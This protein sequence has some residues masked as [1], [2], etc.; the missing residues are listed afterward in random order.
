M[1]RRFLTVFA[2]ISV[3][4][5]MLL[6]FSVTAYVGSF[7]DARVTAEE[8]DAPS[9]EI[10]YQN[11]S[12]RDNVCIKFALDLKNVTDAVLLVWT[13]PQ[14]EYVYGTQAA[15][16]DTVGTQKIGNGTYYVYDYTE[17]SAKQM[18]DEIYV[19]GYA[20]I[21]GE[22]VYSQVTRYSIL[23]YALRI[24][25]KIGH[26]EDLTDDQTLISM[27]EQ[28]LEY[29]ASAQ[30]HFRY[31]LDR[32][33]NA[34]YGEVIIDGCNVKDG[35]YNA[36]L[37]VNSI[38]ECSVAAKDS[39]G[40][41]F[42]HWVDYNGTRS[43][44]SNEGFSL[45][46]TAGTMEYAPVYA[47]VE[48]FY[49]DEMIAQMRSYLVSGSS[50]FTQYVDGHAPFMLKNTSFVGGGAVK[51]MGIAVGA[52]KAIDASGNFKLTLGVYKDTDAGRKSAP[53]RTYTVLINGEDHGLT[54]NA[55]QYAEQYAKPVDQYKWIDV[56]L[57]SYAI[58]LGS[59]E[60]LGIYVPEDTLIPLYTNNSTVRNYISNKKSDCLGF[61]MDLGKSNCSLGANNALIVSFDITHYDNGE[62]PFYSERSYGSSVVE[63]I[64]AQSDFSKIP[65]YGKGTSMYTPYAT[66]FYSN[67]T[68][69]SIGF[70]VMKVD[71]PDANGNYTLTISVFD[72]NGLGGKSL[73][74]YKILINKDKYDLSALP[75]WIDIDLLEYNIK[76]SED[77]TFAIFSSTDTI[78]PGFAN[79]KNSP[80]VLNTIPTEFKKFYTSVGTSGYGTNTSS[81]L[82]LDVRMIRENLDYDKKVTESLYSDTL[83]NTIK[84]YVSSDTSKFAKFAIGGGPFLMQAEEFISDGRVSSIGM[85]VTTTTADGSGNYKFTI[86]VYGKDLETGLRAAP[87]RTYEVSVS[88]TKYGLTNACAIKW[89][90]L[91]LSEYNIVLGKDETLA[92]SSEDT[93]DTLVPYYTNNADF[94]KL[95]ES[96]GDNLNGFIKGLGTATLSIEI[97]NSL[98]FN[99]KMERGYTYGSMCYADIVNENESY[100]A[101]ISALKSKYAGKKISIIGDSIST[102]EGY[103]NNASNN[104]TTGNNAYYYSTSETSGLSA[105]D[106]TY[107]MK[108]IDA[109]D[110]ELCVNNSWSGGR[111]YGKSETSYKDSS[112]FRST[113]LHRDAGGQRVEPDVIVF[114]Y[115]INDINNKVTFGNLLN[116]LDG[117]KDRSAEL[118]I[119]DAWFKALL[120]KNVNGSVAGSTYTNF[121]EAYALS[122]YNMKTNYADSEIYCVNLMPCAKYFKNNSGTYDVMEN[123]NY[124]YE[125]MVDYF[126]LYLVDQFSEIAPEYYSYGPYYTSDAYESSN[127]YLPML[128]PNDGGHTRLAKRIITA[129]GKK[130]GII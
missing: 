101:M 61:Y 102:F 85:P 68:I 57:T 43:L 31:K 46:V 82:V 126:D 88:G 65:A 104:S 124:F 114:F 81:A 96:S 87:R 4:A 23:E 83:V 58:N 106:H 100:D 36:I 38:I 109:L 39:D 54:T 77:E 6:S 55:K 49:T 19:R 115:G 14:N 24:T 47:E 51:S 74:D 7:S 78:Y 116:E 5:A 98:I 12:F 17:L 94:R 67:G 53:V 118:E 125:L 89:I 37:P 84:G 22:A 15:K 27:V 66:D 30:K 86:Y 26:G 111:V 107:W 9:I 117:A 32:L 93:S 122:L 28:M 29:G 76:L 119:V 18:T 2:A 33:A 59:D 52:T 25:G 70:P 21:D 35:F 79:T 64:K 3:L 20:N 128:H 112:V 63:S 108:L 10:A 60:S 73:R 1:K 56:D 41:P 121:Q 8:D 95:L 110:M 91:D 62:S 80:N 103:S 105:V 130:N 40:K 113:Q 92:F 129:M 90:E 44:A 48:S 99:L 72:K 127:G 13:A 50:Y 97:K 11:L 42:S 45:R 120:A 123:Y 75:Q 34:E 69:G 16:L 71:S